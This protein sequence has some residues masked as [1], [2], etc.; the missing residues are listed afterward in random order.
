MYRV[1]Y[2][3]TQ[4][5]DVVFYKWFK[6]FKEATKFSIQLK[7]PES[8]TEIKFINENDSDNP[9]PDRSHPSD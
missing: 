9:K 8:I 2:Y 7:I 5:K 6:T 1:T 3:A 4:K